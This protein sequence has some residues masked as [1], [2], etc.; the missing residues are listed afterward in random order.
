MCAL[1]DALE[2]QWIAQEK[3]MPKDDFFAY[4]EKWLVFSMIWSIGATIDE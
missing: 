1:F 2:E 4:T 3:E